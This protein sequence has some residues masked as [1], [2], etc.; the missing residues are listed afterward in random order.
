MNQKLSLK[1]VKVNSSSKTYAA[2]FAIMPDSA[3][4][5]ALVSTGGQYSIKVKTNYGVVS[6]DSAMLVKNSKNTMYI[7]G[8]DT[9]S[10]C[11]FVDYFHHIWSG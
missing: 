2:Q 9:V 7:C 11:Q 6:V 5:K 10:L 1:D 3:A 8:N 4:V